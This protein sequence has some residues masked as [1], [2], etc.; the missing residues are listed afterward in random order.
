[1]EKKKP[2]RGQALFLMSPTGHFAGLANNL[3]LY[4]FLLTLI[5][6]QTKY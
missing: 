2:E 4:S 6:E 1:M 3:K 5:F